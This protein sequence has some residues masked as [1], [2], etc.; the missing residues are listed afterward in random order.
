LNIQ[1]K[2]PPYKVGYKMRG[3]IW[4]GDYSI[5]IDACYTRQIL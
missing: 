1:V 4:L 5:T 2:A 3:G